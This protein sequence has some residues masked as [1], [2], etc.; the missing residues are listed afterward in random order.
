MWID[1]PDQ[2]LCVRVVVVHSAKAISQVSTTVSND[3]NAIP[4]WQTSSS[5]QPC[6]GTIDADPGTVVARHYAPLSSEWQECQY[7]HSNLRDRRFVARRSPKCRLQQL[8]CCELKI[9][10]YFIMHSTKCQIK[11]GYKNHSYSTHRPTINVG[12]HYT[13]CSEKTSTFVFLHHS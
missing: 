5:P 2:P 10:S 12:V 3:H 6:N 9:L 11:T 1:W 13:L 7:T 4:L 8:K